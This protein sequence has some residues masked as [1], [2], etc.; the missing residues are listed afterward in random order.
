MSG[1]MRSWRV[2]HFLRFGERNVRQTPILSVNR[3]SDI[4][5]GQSDIE[6]LAARALADVID[7]WPQWVHRRVD[8]VHPLEGERGRLKHSI[9]CTPVPEPLLA[10]DQTERVR[11]DINDVH[12]LLMVPLAFISKGPMRHLDALDARGNSL[13]LMGASESN[14]LMYETVLVLLEASGVRR[15]DELE[16]IVRVILS[17]EGMKYSAQVRELCEAGRWNGE[18]IWAEDVFLSNDVVDLVEQL[19]SS[20]LLIG[21]VPAR[22]SGIRQVVKFSYH[23][24]IEEEQSIKARF[25]NLFVAIGWAE[26]EIVINMH[27]PHATASYHLEFQTPPQL[28]VRSLHLPSSDVPNPVFG[29]T[30]DD[31]SGVPVAHV[32]GAYGFLPKDD[33]IVRLAV[34]W[35]GLRVVTLFVTSLTALIFFLA[36]FLDGATPTLREVGGNA[37]ALFLAV[38]A[39]F[40][41]FL[42]STPENVSASRALVPLR[43]MLMTCALLLFAMAGSLVGKLHLG[44]LL[45]LWWVGLIT[46]LVLAFLLASAGLVRRI[47]SAMT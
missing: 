36:L 4:G 34:P 14:P 25:L 45:L 28:D 8:S 23:W 5:F 38:P 7:K 3:D 11:T 24:V 30:L 12:G 40:I 41:S 26:K 6:A 13:P 9:D 1:A 27:M 17:D 35:R 19:A 20:F 22:D 44:P 32:H 43:I 15:S 47:F 16:R 39:V 21:L 18:Q 37:A 29:P 33:A 31:D 2:M 42:A 10:Y 46:S